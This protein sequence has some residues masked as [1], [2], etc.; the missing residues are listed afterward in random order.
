MA[1]EYD[2][3][4]KQLEVLEKIV[5]KRPADLDEVNQKTVTKI[6]Q[7]FQYVGEQIMG[8][9]FENISNSTIVNRSMLDNALNSLTS[10]YGADFKKAL[11][12]VADHIDSIKD[13]KS[14]GLLDGM[15]KE[16]NSNNQ[17]N[18][19]S[20]HYGMVWSRLYRIQQR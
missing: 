16:L 13:T 18:L 17:T 7:K 11:K 9:K 10:E 14:A 3:L 1:D 12:D 2:V 15:S 4:L 6:V 20:L 5:I 19:F 8:D